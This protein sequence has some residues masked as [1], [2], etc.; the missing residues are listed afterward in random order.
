MTW[1][2]FKSQ[3]LMGDWISFNIQG[4]ADPGTIAVSPY[5]A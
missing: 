5:S 3:N 1:L 4:L 2:N